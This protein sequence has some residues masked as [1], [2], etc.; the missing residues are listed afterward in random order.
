MW[1]YTGKCPTNASNHYYFGNYPNILLLE[2]SLSLQIKYSKAKVTIFV[3]K[4]LLSNVTAL[5]YKAK[6]HH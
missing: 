4:P 1:L 2:R 5:W 3:R 6:V